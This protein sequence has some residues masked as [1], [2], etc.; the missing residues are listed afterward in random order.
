MMPWVHEVDHP[1][2]IITDE[3]DGGCNPR[4]NTLI[5]AAMPDSELAFLKS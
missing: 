1:S 3:F 2:I 4:L 5:D